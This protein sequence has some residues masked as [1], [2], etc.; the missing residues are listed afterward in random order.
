LL[1]DYERERED[2]KNVDCIKTNLL[3]VSWAKDKNQ[4]AAEACHMPLH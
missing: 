3:T 4:A 2:G 1:S